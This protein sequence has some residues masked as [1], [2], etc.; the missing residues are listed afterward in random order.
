MFKH[1]IIEFNDGFNII[2]GDND[3]GKSTVLEALNLVLTG[4]VYNV[5]IQSVLNLSL[6]NKDVREEFKKAL[7]EKPGEIIDLPSIEVEAY[8][9]LDDNDNS[10]RGSKG[11][12]NSLCEDAYGIKLEI[13]FNQ[14]NSKAYKDLLFEKKLDDIPLELYKIVYRTFA[15]PDFYI[16]KT[17][18]I[19]MFID[20]TKRDYSGVLNKF[21]SSNF[22][23][24]LS[25]SDVAELRIAYKGNKNEFINNKTVISLNKKINDDIAFKDYSLSINLKDGEVDAWKNDIEIKF[26]DVSIANMGF[27]TQNMFKTQLVTQDNDDISLLLL[28]EPE[29]SLSFSN[30]SI[31]INKL[32]SCSFKQVFI[33]THSSFVANKLGL[34]NLL[35]INNGTIKKFDNLDKHAYKYFMSLPGYNTLRLIL[36][37]KTI[38]VEGPADELIVQ[39]AYLDKHK[40]LPIEDGVDVLSV[41]GIA[42]KSYCQLAVI[43]NKK[44][45]VVT[46]NDGKSNKSDLFVDFGDNIK[47]CIESNTSLKTLEPS[48]LDANK[49]SFEKF[50]RIIY[51]GNDIDKIDY[52]KLLDFMENNKTTWSLRVFESNEKIQYPQYILSA[53][54]DE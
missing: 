36:S 6:F 7:K 19:S 35:L 53:I 4:K 48:I 39:K 29:N 11:T 49:D 25:E 18:K 12:N 22:I 1:A 37:K 13:V 2:V 33:A 5:N 38:L 17:S 15:T 51:R 24:N 31:M 45:I 30:M 41:G 21:I 54:E 8:L 16:A 28:E 52:Q 27:G 32:A 34:N 23:G 14:D 3:A 46:D 44:V 20:A 9:K 10:F 50:K 43:V 26:N 40:K 47:L 42:F